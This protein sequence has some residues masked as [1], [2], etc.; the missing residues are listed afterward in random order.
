MAETSSNTFL[1]CYVKNGKVI[2]QIFL[3][4]P[5][6]VKTMEAIGRAK[7]FETE[8]FFIGDDNLPDKVENNITLTEQEQNQEPKRPWNKWIKCLET[9]RVFPTVREC[10][11]Q[12][13]I[14]YMTIINCVKNGNA[15]R[16]FH[17]VIE[18]ERTEAFRNMQTHKNDKREMPQRKI[19]C[20][21][22][23]A[24]FDSVKECLRKCHLPVSSFYRA[25]HGGTPIKGLLFMYE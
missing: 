12:M 7:G 17:F 20:V 2:D 16:N 25:L 3:N 15:T 11:N 10:S 22:T 5:D 19:I 23:G 13:G 6:E 9:G 1:T 8:T 18:R 4:N 21:T 14:P 24:R